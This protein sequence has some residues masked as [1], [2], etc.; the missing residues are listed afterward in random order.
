MRF[1]ALDRRSFLLMT[2]ALG[3]G[4]LSWPRRVRAQDRSALRI[5]SDS[6]LQVPDP[7]NRLAQPEGDIMDAIFSNLI[8]AKPGDTWDWR[9]Q[10]SSRL[11]E[12]HIDFML[13]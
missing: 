7:L 12:R 1:V 10:R 9:R 13:R 5:R 11:T 4:A 8:K 3:A 2:T 6:D